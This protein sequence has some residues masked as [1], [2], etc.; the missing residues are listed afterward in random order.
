MLAGREPSPQQLSNALDGQL[1][2]LEEA[3]RTA[4]SQAQRAH[5]KEGERK[6]TQL[7]FRAKQLREKLSKF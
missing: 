2:A 6:A 1:E 3:L 4:V 7:L 5:D